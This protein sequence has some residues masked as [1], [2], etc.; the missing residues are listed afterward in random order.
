[1]SQTTFVIKCIGCKTDMVIGINSQKRLCDDCQNKR[2]LA[3]RKS[4]R[5]I[6]RQLIKISCLYC[7]KTYY[8]KG[9][10]RKFCS[11][12]CKTKIENIRRLGKNYNRII[13]QYKA[14]SPRLQQEFKRFVDVGL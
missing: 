10:T 2:K 7:D 4:R 9:K 5:T 11:T 14:L 6:Q 12:Q 13:I 8:A 1:M 3:A